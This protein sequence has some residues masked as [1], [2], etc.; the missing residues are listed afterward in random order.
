MSRKSWRGGEYRRKIRLTESYA[1]REA[2]GDG[3]GAKKGGEEERDEKSGQRKGKNGERGQS[4]DERQRDRGQEDWLGGP[5][6]RETEREKGG[7]RGRKLKGPGVENIGF[8]KHDRKY[9]EDF[10]GLGPLKGS[11]RN[12]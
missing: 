1:K 12:R 11:Y 5:R 6:S 3:G 10:W 9:R 4:G 2:R 7:R 8:R